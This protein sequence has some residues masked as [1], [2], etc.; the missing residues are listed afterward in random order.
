MKK[1]LFLILM[2]LLGALLGVERETL[3]RFLLRNFLSKWTTRKNLNDFRFNIIKRRTNA[4]EKKKKNILYGPLMYVVT[5]F[6]FS[7]FLLEV[8]NRQ[9]YP[10]ALV[11][12][13]K[14]TCI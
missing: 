7:V 8:T 6:F 10:K 12:L 3:C 11:A 13:I 4:K 1:R 2:H 9:F 14:A 5:H